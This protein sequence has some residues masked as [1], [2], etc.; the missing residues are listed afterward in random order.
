MNKNNIKQKLY[1]KAARFGFANF[2]ID[3]PQTWCEKMAWLQL[4]DDI[5]L[6]A[7]CADKIGV[8]GYSIEKLGKDICVPF[9]KVYN[10]S[11][12][13]IKFSELPDKFVLK[14]NHGWNMNIVVDDK[15]SCSQEDCIKK[16][17]K[18][19][20][21]PFGINSVEPHYL[22]IERKCFAERHIG[23]PLDY[24]F[25]CFNGSPFFCTVNSNIGENGGAH[26]NI[27]WYDMDWNILPYSRIDHPT[28]PSKLDTKPS[29]FELMK[30]YAKKLSADFR[31]VRVD[32]YEVDGVVYLGELTFTPATGFIK[33]TDPK[34]D[35]MFGDMLKL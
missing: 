35:R 31:F 15:H 32:F 33:W 25:W 29:Q 12:N 24:K 18:W 23:K 19:I 8:H 17:K 9:L 27:N 5:Q 6:R 1:D 34:I 30:E 13:E 11:P 22:E 20:D 4:N 28:N 16:I 14:C 2:N 10:Y 7:R 26:Y 21:T 3:N